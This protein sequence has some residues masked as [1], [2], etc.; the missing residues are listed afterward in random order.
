MTEYEIPTSELDTVQIG[1]MTIRQIYQGDNL[2]YERKASWFM[3]K[4]VPDDYTENNNTT[5]A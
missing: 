5:E 2:L 1:N 4:L 3:L